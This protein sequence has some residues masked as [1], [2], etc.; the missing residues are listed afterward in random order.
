MSSLGSRCQ[1]LNDNGSIKTTK[2]KYVAHIEQTAT[3]NNHAVRE[4]VW[5]VEEERV[6]HNLW[7]NPA[8]LKVLAFAWKVLL[9]RVPTKTN[10]T[11][12]NV[13]APEE[14][15]L[16]PMCNGAEE[17]SIHL[18]LHCQLACK[19]WYK[20]MWWLDG[21]FVIPPNLFVHWE[22]WSGRVSNKP[23]LKGLRLIWLTTLWVLWK[24]R[25]IKNLTGLIMRSRKLWKKLRFYLGSGCYIGWISRCAF[26]TSGV[27]TPKVASEGLG[28]ELSWPVLFLVRCCSCWLHVAGTL[29]P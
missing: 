7:K 6:F 14:S 10:L 3:K 18:F 24:A 29:W 16:C 23:L 8:P 9:N 4:D 21:Y 17:S 25:M 1:W 12:R 13:L 28:W 11:F 27:G 19:V 20:L 5:D 22:C 26:F 15:T 2:N